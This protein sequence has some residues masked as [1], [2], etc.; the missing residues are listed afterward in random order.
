MN[1]SGG[2]IVWILDADTGK[3]S[4]AMIQAEEQAKRTGD[5]VDKSFGKTSGSFSQH[6]FSMR[7]SVNGLADSLGGLVKASAV[8]LAGV[9][10]GLGTFVKTASDLE[11]TNKQMG[12][13]IGS[14]QDAQRVFGELYNYTLGK[15]IA[16]PDASKAA[17]TLLGYGRTQATVIDDMKTLSTLSIVNGADLQALSVVFGQVN[18]RG[19]LF[20]QDALQL[21]NNNIPLTTILARKFGISMEEAADR[22]NGGKVSAV[23]FTDAMKQYANS[24]DISSMSNTFQNRMIS[25]QGTIR[26]VGLS[27]LGIKIDPLQGLVVESG[28]LFDT[29]SAGLAELVT[30]LKTPEVKEGMKKFGEDLAASFKAAMPVVKD[31]FM[32]MVQNLPLIINLTKLLIVTWIALKAAAIGLSVIGTVTKVFE[33]FRGATAATTIA[34]KATTTSVKSLVKSMTEG[35]TGIINMFQ[36]LGKAVAGPQIVYI[37]AGM[38]AFIAVIGVLRIAFELLKPVLEFFITQIKNVMVALG[39]T[40]IGIINAVTPIILGLATIIGK[41]LVEALRELGKIVVTIINVIGG[42]FTTYLKVLRDVVFKL[43]DGFLAW[44]RLFLEFVDLAA[45][46]GLS[47]AAGITALSGAL[48]I[49]LSVIG[50][51]T[52]ASGAS[53]LLGGVATG[54]GNLVSGSKEKT[55]FA[56]LVDNLTKLVT[57]VERAN[58]ANITQLPSQIKGLVNELSNLGS[59]D[60]KGFIRFSD[61]FQ[62]AIKNF[63]KVNEASRNINEIG[64]ALNWL[65]HIFGDWN[66][67]KLT[68]KSTI[69]RDSLSRLMN[70]N[71][72][73]GLA[74]LKELGDSLENLNWLKKIL[75]D[76]KT[77]ELDAKTKD[78][79]NALSNLTTIKQGVGLNALRDLGDAISNLQK[80]RNVFDG[81]VTKS[82]EEQTWHIR[83]GVSNL[84]TIREGNGLKALD[85]VGNSLANLRNIRDTFASW[86]TTKFVEKTWHIRDGVSNLVTIREGN[87]LK[88]LDGIG[89][90]LA[91]FRLIRDII[92]GWNTDKFVENTVKI[93]DGI[94]NLVTIRLGAG[95]AGLDGLGNALANFRL[96]RDVVSAWDTSKFVE[97]TVAIRDGVSNLVT[98][99]QGAGFSVLDGIGNQIANL[100]AI[101]TVVSD[102]DTNNFDKKSREIRNGI[103]QFAQMNTGPG[104]TV[105]DGIG[106]ALANL[107]TIRTIVGDWVV[108]DFVAKA[109]QVREGISHFAQINTGPGF[110]VLMNIQNSLGNLNWIKFIMGNWNTTEFA[111]KTM[112]VANGI[113]NFSSADMTGLIR[114]NGIGGALENLNWL[115]MIL[116]NWDANKSLAVLT[117]LQKF[118]QGITESGLVENIAKAAGLIADK[119]V[120]TLETKSVQTYL[121]GRNHADSFKRGFGEYPIGNI[122]YVAGYMADRVVD[123]LRNKSVAVWWEGRNVADSFKRGIGEYPIQNLQA[124]G[125]YAV[126]GFIQGVEQKNVY[127]VGWNVADKF[128][129]GLKDRAKQN[130]PWKTTMESGQFAVQGLVEGIK[131]TETLA[132]RAA[133]HLA[134]GVVTAMETSPVMSP[135]MAMPSYAGIAPDAT[136]TGVGGRGG[137]ASNA[138]TINQTNNVYTELDMQKVNRDLAWDLAKA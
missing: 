57:A 3:F 128:L 115:K 56:G 96:V 60:M 46:K 137:A 23:E 107:R 16:F 58:K 77:N 85:G 76:W 25:L 48:T 97:K 122:N 98:I 24:L 134:D 22:I 12:I 42:I 106:N 91:N 64:G 54:I 44:T 6:I 30:W 100:K 94:S 92:S 51:G 35:F 59:I 10:V 111:T 18:S 104:F 81:W 126:T 101:R 131:K 29:L 53:N 1:I 117:S 119:L 20:G 138:P 116:G 27:L 127:S 38:A 32:F 4:K 61:D 47:A 69:I 105:L 70:I 67:D 129:K 21:I 124:A 112:Q 123:M 78:I 118:V 74:P 79:R 45:K 26:S 63:N 80:I 2:A 95:L 110:T 109:K 14:T 9:G 34:A 11:T 86:D 84:V 5:A 121:Q 89:N 50:G 17:K 19:A 40:F 33:F 132:V 103:S 43:V 93:R 88:A 8:A 135:Q 108:T 68:E 75:G 114:F 31:L 39:P 113:K 83:D 133:Q 37:L 55:G 82:F 66:T 73:N 49:L 13:L 36:A 62:K 65:K 28:G 15:P 130:S 125:N 102:W 72:G 90:Q 120:A 7:D 71:Q 52:L 136:L 99:R 87:G 41:V